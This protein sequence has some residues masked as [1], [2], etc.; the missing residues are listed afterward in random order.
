MKV[1]NASE[2]LDPLA[3]KINLTNDHPLVRDSLPIPAGGFVIVRFIADNIGTRQIKKLI[4][5]E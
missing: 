4:L 2:L 1:G 5:K 3:F